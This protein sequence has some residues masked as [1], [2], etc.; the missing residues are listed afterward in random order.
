MRKNCARHVSGGNMKHV[1]LS[2]L[3]LI[4]LAFVVSSC[5]KR[6]PELNPLL[7]LSGN[8][9]ST[10]PQNGT[11]MVAVLK[12]K[13]PALLESGEKKEGRLVIDQDRLKQIQDEQ[14][15]AIA[16]LKELSPEI[17]VIYQYKMVLNGLAVLAPSA[18]ADKLKAVGFVA[19]AESSGQFERERLAEGV[20]GVLSKL[21]ERN[22]SKFIG[23]EALNQKGITGRGIKVGVIDTGI[24]YTHAMLGGVGTEDA[25]KAVNPSEPNAGFPNAKVLGGI[26]LVGTTYNAASPEFKDRIPKP[27]MNPLDEAGHG[28]HV[29]GTVAGHGN[30]VTSYNGMAPDADLYAIKVFGAEGSTS[31][32]VV[33][34]ALEFAADPNVDGANEDQLN[35][36]NLSLGSSYGNPHILYSEAIRNLVNGGTV[37]VASAGNSGAK[38]YIVGAP[39]T[40]DAAI[41]VAASVDNGDHNW[42]F[43]ASRLNL[44]S[45]TLLVE[46]I[47]AATTQKIADGNV[48]GAL[49]YAGLAA[50][51]FTD[52]QAQA[53]RGQVALIDRGVVNFNDK[54]RRAA[55]AGAIGV[56][57]ANNREGAAFTMGTTDKFDIPAI[58]ITQADGQKAKDAMAQ[59][60]VTVDFKTDAVI[61]KPELVDTL[62]DFS[63]KGPRSIDGA[64][65][66]EI[67]APGS[68]VISAAMGHGAEVVQM[69]GTSMAAP[70]VAGVMALLKQAQPALSADELKAILMGGSKTIGST[71]GR[72]SVSQ[73]GAGRVQAD[74]SAAIKMVS[75]VP[76]I[77][78]GEV[79]LETQ[80]TIRRSL[81]LKNLTDA[82]LSLEVVL[83]GKESLSMK[84]LT[85]ELPAR[86]EASAVVDIKLDATKMPAGDVG[87]MDGWV[88]FKQNGQ[89]V[90]RI[91]VLAVAH[92]L[93]SVSAES[94]TVH[95]TSEVDAAGSAAD[96]VLKN[97]NGNKAE[98]L[99]FNLIGQDERKP[100]APSF[101]S[102]DCDMQSVGYRIV[103][104]AAGAVNKL[105][106]AIKLYK[107][108]TTWHACD[109]SV[110][111]DADGDGQ[112][113]Q[114]LLGSNLKSIPGQ[115]A[116]NFATTLLDAK[117]A[118]EIRRNYEQS[119]VEAQNDP[120]KLAALKDAEQ[121]GDAIL[122]QEALKVYNNSS[123]AVLEMPVDQLAVTRDG[124]LA[125]KVIV[126]HNEQSSVEFDDQLDS[127]LQLNGRLS[128]KP[129]DQSFVDLP[130]A[131]NLGANAVQTVG[132]TK[133]EGHEKLMVLMPQ[134]R[135]SLSN[136]LEDSQSAL[137]N[138]VFG[139]L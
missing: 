4:S 138:P 41:S 7:R 90:Y 100:N 93:S 29:A 5:T 75:D 40:A 109:I 50:T 22:S 107:P 94:L 67:S 17:Q 35:V 12:L 53:I 42:K 81:A 23:A 45:S 110:M 51:D 15:Q 127:A 77:S 71:A 104:G 46:A 1:K 43:S 48:S 8:I 133:G 31:D 72:Y 139:G 120:K 85:L 66:P 134:N 95:S 33:I 84:P 83:E 128:L 86:G 108:M 60:V 102:S 52:E 97:L 105:Q 44:G 57:V 122:A 61:E 129:E 54:V 111:I 116:E 69:S 11:Q 56:I 37:V 20:Q 132:L 62:T 55:A 32:F 34:A 113:E 101:M 123:V 119:I 92:R 125:F 6:T 126:T 99:L 76:S 25:Y 118:R 87:E 9:I 91:P 63:S 58:M 65:K 74:V 64:I 135:F 18:L 2:L 79:G 137:L 121:Y 115:T 39:G 16:A 38:D 89:E 59:G 117:K 124:S 80:K 131:I 103:R 28:T 24:D 98:V 112:A 49:V 30:G 27:D 21:A 47:Q 68:N 13:T 3:S 19:Y 14:Q 136:L 78:I 130:A 82:A 96:L 73:Q 88:L 10:R 36:V 106:I 114:E 26:D 70:H